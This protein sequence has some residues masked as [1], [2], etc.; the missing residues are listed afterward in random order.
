VRQLEG[1]DNFDMKE[2]SDTTNVKYS[3]MVEQIRKNLNLTTLKY[4]KLDDLDAAIG[5][6]AEKLCTHC[7]KGESYS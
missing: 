1:R 5:L 6:P 3:A 2:Y 7:W 4:Q